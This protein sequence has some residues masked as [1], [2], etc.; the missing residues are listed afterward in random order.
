MTRPE[1]VEPLIVRVHGYRHKLSKCVSFVLPDR[2]KKLT[3]K[4]TC[5][6]SETEGDIMTWTAWYGTCFGAH[7]ASLLGF[8]GGYCEVGK[9]RGVQFNRFQALSSEAPIACQV[10]A[11]VKKNHSADHASNGISCQRRHIL[12]HGVSCPVHIKRHSLQ[13]LPR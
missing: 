12:V 2:F 13:D 7:R 4:E 5:A 9:T 11:H 1:R 3:A 8:T 10:Q 6:A